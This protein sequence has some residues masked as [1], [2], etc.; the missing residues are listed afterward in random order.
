MVCTVY[1]YTLNIQK[2]FA[3]CEANVIFTWKINLVVV[4]LPIIA[5]L[6]LKE[7]FP[8]TLEY[9]WSKELTYM[10]LHS[11][12]NKEKYLTFWVQVY[13]F[14]TLENTTIMIHSFRSTY[15]R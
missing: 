2:R 15:L 1:S 11:P 10:L 6:A 4:I 14:T 13:T 7:Q 8:L 3:I 5:K 9:I 12:E